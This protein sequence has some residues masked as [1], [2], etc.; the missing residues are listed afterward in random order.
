MKWV[1]V[2]DILWFLSSF[3]SPAFYWWLLLAT[4]QQARNTG[5]YSMWN[6]PPEDTERRWKGWVWDKQV[7]DWHTCLFH[8]GNSFRGHWSHYPSFF[9]LRH[10]RFF[11][12]SSEQNQQ[13]IENQTIWAL[14]RSLPL[15]FNIYRVLKM[16]ESFWEVHITILYHKKS[17]RVASMLF[18]YR[19][20]SKGLTQRFRVNK[21]EGCVLG[22]NWWFKDYRNESIKTCVWFGSF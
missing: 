11:S 5:K 20:L 22:N 2:G 19:C 4:N 13:W 10:C 1:V 9:P 16:W 6:K 8:L 18:K 7:W 17:Q 15:S 21:N 3:C 12:A 14:F